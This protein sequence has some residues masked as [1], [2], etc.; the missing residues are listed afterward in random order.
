MAEINDKILIK[1][2]VF[3]KNI[4]FNDGSIIEFNKSDIV[5]FTGANNSGKSQLLKDILQYFIAK[6][7]KLTKIITHL[8]G[9]F[10]GDIDYLLNN[11]KRN[12]DGLCWTGKSY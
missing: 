2:E 4:T 7:K 1:P 6:E 9:D 10:L 3:V 5:V 11:A 8:E 12:T